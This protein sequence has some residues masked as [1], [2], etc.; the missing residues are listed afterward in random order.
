VRTSLDLTI[1]IGE[2]QDAIAIDFLN[3]EIS[4]ILLII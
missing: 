4:S 3:Y 1:R 2:F